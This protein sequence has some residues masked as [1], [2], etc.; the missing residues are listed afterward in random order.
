MAERVLIRRME[1]RRTWD[2][3]ELVFGGVKGGKPLNEHRI[4]KNFTLVREKAALP[5]SIKF[6]SCRHTFASWLLTESGM[7]LYTVSRWLGHRDIKT[8]VN[9]YGHL[10]PTGS[11]VAERVFA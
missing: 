10:V 4:W 1:R 3:T 6:H 9:T 8:T 11:E 5:D 7:N 2:D